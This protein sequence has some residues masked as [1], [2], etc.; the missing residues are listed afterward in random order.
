M[1]AGIEVADFKARLADSN[2]D[3]RTFLATDYLNH[4]NEIIMLLDL[5]SAMPDIFDEIRAWQ[6]AGY[7]E[8]FERSGLSGAGLA[9]EAYELAPTEHRLPFDQTIE[10]MNR[11]VLFVVGRMG[12]FMD[13]NDSDGF[14]GLAAR[15]VER[16]QRLNAVADSIIHCDV[17]TLDQASIDQMLSQTC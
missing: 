3:Q 7:V 16:L 12:A 17:P 9:I 8:H 2:I 1:D 5:A 15:S 10:S 6:P 4:F 11:L 14:S 13:A